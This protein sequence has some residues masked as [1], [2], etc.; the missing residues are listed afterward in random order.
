M[1]VGNEHQRD[2]HTCLGCKMG[3]NPGCA[4]LSFLSRARLP[5]L[6]REVLGREARLPTGP[7]FHFRR[8]SALDR[9]AHVHFA[10]VFRPFGMEGGKVPERPFSLGKWTKNAC[11]MDVGKWTSVLA[12]PEKWTSVRPRPFR[13]HSA[14]IPRPFRCVCAA[15]ARSR[16]HSVTFAGAFHGGEHPFPV[17]VKNGRKLSIEETPIS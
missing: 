17:H 1:D 5:D 6:A 4:G 16:V 9:D 2:A 14:P 8:L 11:K 10:S 13:A 3:V 7:D 12:L 15:N